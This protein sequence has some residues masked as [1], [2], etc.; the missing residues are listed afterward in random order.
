MGLMSGLADIVT[1]GGSSAAKAAKKG[2]S[3][4]QSAEEQNK[5]LYGTQRAQDLAAI[6]ESTDPYT[7]SASGAWSEYQNAANA[8]TDQYNFDPYEEF[9]TSD[10]NKYLDPSLDYQ[11]EQATQSVEGSA[12]NRG[13]L[14]SGATG[15]EI[16]KQSQDIAKTGYNDALQTALSQYQNKQDYGTAAKQQAG[17][18]AQQNLSNLQGVSSTAMNQG[19]LGTQNTLQSNA[20]YYGNMTGANTNLANIKAQKA[21]ANTGLLN[22]TMNALPQWVNMA[23][24]VGKMTAGV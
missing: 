18:L 16:L 23:Q 15:Q 1:L 14:F 24:Q 12:A 17:N 5:S 6:S 3:A 9:S 10:V 2:L 21:A 7:K 8:G 13:K 20:N 22:Q 11:T 19:N 4:Q